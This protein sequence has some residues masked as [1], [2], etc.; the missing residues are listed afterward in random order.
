MIVNVTFSI[1][2]VFDLVSSNITPELKDRLI[3]AVEGAYN[4]I[5][6]QVFPDA[7]RN[8]AL[9]SID[10]NN[11]IR[12]IK[13]IREATGWSLYETKKFCDVVRGEPDYSMGYYSPSDPQQWVPNVVYTG[14]TTN[15]LIAAKDVVE[16][17]ATELRSLGCECEIDS[18]GC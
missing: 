16:N 3:D 8:L 9:K 15:V 5:E 2:E 18:W 1:R 7:N 13:A 11:R 12:I 14:G 4:K 17:L 10:P 6:N